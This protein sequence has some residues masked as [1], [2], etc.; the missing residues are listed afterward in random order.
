MLTVEYSILVNRLPVDDFGPKPLNIDPELPFHERMIEIQKQLYPPKQRVRRFKKSFRFMDLP[1]EVRNRVYR[2]ATEADG[3]LRIRFF[4]PAAITRASRQLRAES[5]PIFFDVNVFLLEIRASYT[6]GRFITPQDTRFKQAGTLRLRQ[7]TIK[8]LKGSGPNAV[9]VK[10]LCLEV[11][12]YYAHRGRAADRRERGYGY[13]CVMLETPTVPKDARIERYMRSNTYG[14]GKP[15]YFDDMEYITSTAAKFLERMIAKQG[16]NGLSA[17][18]MQMLA[19][20]LRV[21]PSEDC[22]V[23]PVREKRKRLPSRRYGYKYD[24]EEEGPLILEELDALI[25]G[26]D[27][28]F[29]GFGDAD[30]LQ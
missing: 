15:T 10:N 4:V 12:D 28:E 26:E 7:E 13:A 19:N 6:Y 2:I 20:T 25:D 16:Y 24:D 17:K 27:E 8:L 9:R 23:H 14:G 21:E 30:E 5:L 11:Q 1:A 3:Q 22:E 18:D 29:Q